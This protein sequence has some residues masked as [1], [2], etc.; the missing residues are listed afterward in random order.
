[1]R[2]LQADLWEVYRSRAKPIV[3]ICT[4][5]S[6][7]LTS[8]TGEQA[9][10]KW[11]TIRQRHK[12]N[13]QALGNRPAFLHWRMVSF[14]TRPVLARRQ[15]GN[16]LPSYEQG[17]EEGAFVP[18]WAL[19]ARLDV[20]AES[21]QALIQMH[22]AYGWGQVYLPRPGCGRGGLQLR[23]IL[24]LLKKTPDWLYVIDRRK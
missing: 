4:N 7:L 19:R 20:I 2:L 13:I 5:G 14:P 24:P 17:Y 1:M 3:C 22:D 6:E 8:Q 18:G 9:M 11:G 12:E 21:L 16:V 10:A 23:D 15:D